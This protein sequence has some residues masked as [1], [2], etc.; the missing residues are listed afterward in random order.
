[1][2]HPPWDRN[3]VLVN[4][5]VWIGNQ[6]I[7]RLDVSVIGG[8][9]IEKLGIDM[10]FYHNDCNPGCPRRS[11]THAQ[12]KETATSN[13]FVLT[14]GLVIQKWRKWLFVLVSVDFSVQCQNMINVK[15]IFYAVDKANFKCAIVN[16]Q[17]ADLITLHNASV[18]LMLYCY[19]I[20]VF[21]LS[22]SGNT[23]G[24][25]KSSNARLL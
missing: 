15:S 17:L 20:Y 4:S 6:L 18:W 7:S 22:I 23:A 12:C 19:P 2:H 13:T 3:Y 21:V 9:R 11:L 24:A 8:W 5:S 16:L 1:M 14:M 10:L 25:Q